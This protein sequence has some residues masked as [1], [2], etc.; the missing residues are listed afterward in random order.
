MIDAVTRDLNRYLKEQDAMSDYDDALEAK[1]EEIY[2]M[3][4]WQLMK[5]LEKEI[6]R[7]TLALLVEEEAHR[8]VQAAC[9][10]PDD[11]MEPVDL[12]DPFWD[13]SA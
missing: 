9:E 1:Q 3:T 6:D 5:M 11:P 8:Q 7:E 10:D 4:V 12:E 13:R 2:D